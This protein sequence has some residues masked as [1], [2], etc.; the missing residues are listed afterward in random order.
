VGYRVVVTGRLARPAGSCGEY[1][2]H[3]GYAAELSVSTLHQEGPAS[4]PVLRAADHLRGALRDSLGRVFPPKEAGLLMGLALGD[5]SRLDPIVAE[6]FKATGLTHLL[7]VSGE[8]VAM[9]LAPILGLS[10]MARLGRRLTLFVGL[11]A[12]AFFVVLTRAEPSVLR[13]AAMTSLAMFGAFV[14]R[15]RSPPALMGGAVLV[16]LAFDPTLVYAIGFQLSVA[17]TAGIPALAAPVA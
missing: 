5:T 1:L 16:L 2:R 3:R 6:R 10:G 9:F 7:A 14:G 8:N 15:P 11:M 17:A 12:V 13:A 4:G